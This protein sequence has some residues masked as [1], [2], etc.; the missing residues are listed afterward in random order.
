MP[1]FD[2]ATATTAPRLI[3]VLELSTAHLPEN[4]GDGRDLWALPGITVYDLASAQ[5][6]RPFVWVP[7]DPRDHI[8]DYLSDCDDDQ[9]ADLETVLRIQEY[10]RLLGCDYV[11]FDP[12]GDTTTDLPTWDW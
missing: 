11:I 6:T 7:D 2:T 9:A 10:A 4:L 5:L 12:D 8:E 3:G 1:Y